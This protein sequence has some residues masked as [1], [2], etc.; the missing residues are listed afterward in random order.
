M[1]VSD[2]KGLLAEVKK[3]MDTQVE[4]VRRELCRVSRYG[5]QLSCVLIDIDRFRYIN[6]RLGQAAGDDVLRALARSLR[7]SCRG[8]DYFGRYGGEEFCVVLPQ[9]SEQQAA[10][11]AERMRG[12]IGE[13][14]VT[15][16]DL[17][18]GITASFG[19]AQRLA[20]TSSPEVLVDMADQ[21]LVVAKRS[22]RRE[23]VDS[24]QPQGR[25]G[26]YQDV[27]EILFDGFE[28]RFQA[29]L[30]VLQLHQVHLGPIQIRRRGNQFQI[31]H[32]GIQHSL[33]SHTRFQQQMV[34]GRQGTIAIRR[35]RRRRV[36]LGIGIHKEYFFFQDSKTGPHIDGGR[37]LSNPS[38]LICYG[39]DFP[40]NN[41]FGYR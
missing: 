16:N 28:G 25:R 30:P 41:G 29:M 34:G 1:D 35:Q 24:D 13:L 9:T 38:F 8:S 17:Q 14:C 27:I 32:G 26:I 39:N 15:L 3:R 36:G 31:I 23:H 7:A 19:V 2:V 33:S 4:H 12:R 37:G 20:D 6:E 21:A 18:L 5:L 11:W 10:Q 22:G 40:Q